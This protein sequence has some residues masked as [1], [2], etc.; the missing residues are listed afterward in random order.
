MGYL[1]PDG[2][3]I[4]EENDAADPGAG[5]SDLLNQS[6]LKIPAAVRNVLVSEF[7]DEASLAGEAAVE[8][9]DAALGEASVLG[10]Q[11]IDTTGDR[12]LGF[13]DPSD[14]A[15]DFPLGG[16]TF[17]APDDGYVWSVST[18]D[19]EGGP[20][21]RRGGIPVD[22][23]GP[24][25]FR[26]E[27]GTSLTATGDLFVKGDSIA[28]AWSVELAALLAARGYPGR[29]QNYAIGGENT[30]TI[31]GRTGGSPWLAAVAGGE[32][33]ASGPVNV[34]LS[35]E[36]GVTADAGTVPKLGPFGQDVQGINPVTLVGDD[37]TAVRGILAGTGTNPHTFTRLR[38]GAA[39][40]AGWPLAVR[41]WAASHTMHGVQI[42]ATGQNDD[43][44]IMNYSRRFDMIDKLLDR[45]TVGR[46]RYLILTAFSGG[47]TT[48]A[49]EE[50][51]AMRRYGRHAILT[52]PLLASYAAL[53]L[54]GI[55]PTTADDTAIA[56]GGVP[57][58][59]F[60]V[61]DPVHPNAAGRT[62]IAHLIVN[63]LAELEYI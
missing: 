9:V 33:P 8:A 62:V 1:D 12:W 23:G 14:P 19:F 5:F 25:T 63:R 31:I 36:Y 34:T 60:P 16:A 7:S 6:T 40:P 2:F 58:S 15:R 43:G 45:T 57:P 55:T 42:I 50:A 4:Y 59:F 39:V 18:E 48:R 37:G 51:E 41:T 46:R 13:F 26:D 20:L 21:R 49:T 44:T 22:R 32:I 35:D 56:G 11:N 30:P 61:G 24:S 3:W 54:A 27:F 28:R 38:A 53:E 10:A 52:R 17:D 47:P 29:V